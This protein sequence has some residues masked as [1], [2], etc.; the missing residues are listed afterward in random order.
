MSIAGDA[1][2]VICLSFEVRVCSHSWFALMLEAV[3]GRKVSLYKLA[4]ETIQVEI[5]PSSRRRYL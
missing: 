1:A 2:G 3:Q 4:S 5:H